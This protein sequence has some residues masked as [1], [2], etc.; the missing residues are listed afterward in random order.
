MISVSI[1]STFPADI[2]LE[3]CSL[4]ADDGDLIDIDQ[5]GMLVSV[6]RSSLATEDFNKDAFSGGTTLIPGQRLGLLWVVQQAT[7][8]LPVKAHSPLLSCRSQCSLELTYRLD[9]AASAERFET[10][11]EVIVDLPAAIF[12]TSLRRIVPPAAGLAP[13]HGTRRCTVGR[14]TE[15]EVIIDRVQLVADLAG[16]TEDAI[17]PELPALSRSTTVLGFIFFCVMT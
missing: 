6:G 4:K 5:N 14:F 17:I 13:C 11:K 12:A 7:R 10:T 1:E 16:P 3:T 15:F 9:S 2:Y 8:E